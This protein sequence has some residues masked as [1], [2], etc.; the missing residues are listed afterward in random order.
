MIC[1]LLGVSCN[2]SPFDQTIVEVPSMPSI[3]LRVKL[4]LLKSNFDAMHMQVLNL[5]IV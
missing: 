3:D 4:F 5:K 1:P 2:D